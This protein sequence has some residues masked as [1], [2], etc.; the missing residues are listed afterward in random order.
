V[1][2]T[3]AISKKRGGPG[4]QEVEDALSLPR[5]A[6]TANFSALQYAAIPALTLEDRGFRHKEK[7]PGG[8]EVPAPSSSTATEE[9][10]TRIIQG[11]KA[12][13]RFLRIHKRPQPLEEAPALRYL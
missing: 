6:P 3:G 13:F 7:G 12:S 11:S 10:T 8:D 2:R 1:Q 9:V 5:T 4:P